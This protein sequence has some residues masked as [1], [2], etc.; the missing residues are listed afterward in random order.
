MIC[1]WGK[2]R[3]NARFP[4]HWG[5]AVR[6]THDMYFYCAGGYELYRVFSVLLRGVEYAKLLHF[7]ASHRGPDRKLIE[8][9]VQIKLDVKLCQ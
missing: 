6:R 4:L 7:N 5:V 8:L 3:A 9:T 1:C 2:A